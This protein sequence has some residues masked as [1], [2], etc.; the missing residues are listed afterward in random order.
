MQR[1]EF[2]K[3]GFAGVGAMGAASLALSALG[4]KAH[5]GAHM[6]QGTSV[7]GAALSGPYLDLRTGRGNQLA[8]ARLQGDLDWGKQKYFWFKGYV[9]GNRPMKKIQNLIGAQGF[10]VIRLNEREDGVIERMCREIILYTDLR[11]GEV[12]DEWDNPFT[13]ERVRIVHVA[14]DPYNYTI[15]KYF[16]PPPEFGGLNKE[17]APPKI[18][19][20]LPWYQHGD[21]NAQ[22]L[23]SEY[24][25]RV[26]V[27]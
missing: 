15:D 5:A 16:P 2:L 17:K 4:Q 13:N 26:V 12:L 3:N 10:G 22:R 24:R 27:A 23:V 21:T 1:R 18:P 19:F 6:Q 8:Y 9:A 25:I 7:G 14:N 11:T 20:I